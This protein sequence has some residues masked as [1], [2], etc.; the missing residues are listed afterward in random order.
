MKKAI[1]ILSLAIFFAVSSIGTSAG[2]ETRVIRAVAFSY[3]GTEPLDANPVSLPV[4]TAGPTD[5]IRFD[6]RGN[7]FVSPHTWTT[8]TALCLYV[9]SR[10]N[11]VKCDITLG[12]P[13]VGTATLFDTLTDGDYVFYCKFHVNAPYFMR[14]LIR[15]RN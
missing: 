13:G 12:G 8:D 2:A 4:V 6:T 10:R 5:T 14:G 9:D 3:V 1:T 7:P 15:V 11:K